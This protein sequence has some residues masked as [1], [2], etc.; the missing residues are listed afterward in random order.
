MT[1]KFSQINMWSFYW[2]TVNNQNNC[3]SQKWLPNFGIVHFG[4]ECERFL[5]V[6]VVLYLKRIWNM[7]H[8]RTIFWILSKI[9]MKWSMNL[10]LEYITINHVSYTFWMYTFLEFKLK[11]I[12]KCLQGQIQWSSIYNRNLNHQSQMWG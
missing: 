10:Q 1:H 12:L 5:F 8:P 4:P 7:A 2:I 6:Y 11:E 3:N 9:L